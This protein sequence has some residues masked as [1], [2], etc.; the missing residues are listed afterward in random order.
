MLSPERWRGGKAQPTTRG[1]WGQD[2][3]GFA[4][5]ATGDAAETVLDYATFYDC[6]N[7]PMAPPMPTPPRTVEDCLGAFDFDDDENVDMV[8]FWVWAEAF[9]GS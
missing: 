2:T 3:Q 1:R 7:G 5:V 6:M 4:L 8:D 9:L